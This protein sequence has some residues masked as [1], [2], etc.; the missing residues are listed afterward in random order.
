MDPIVSI[1]TFLQVMEHGSFSAAARA[2][3]V[4]VSSI[5]RQI[6]A[7]EKHL[8]TA[9]LTRTTHRL[10]PTEAGLNL[11]QHARSALGEIDD[12]I[13]HIQGIDHQLSGKIVLT[14]PLTFGQ[15][16]LTPLLPAFLNQYPALEIDI[17]LT[18]NYLNLIQEGID[19][20]IRVGE[21][22]VPDL[23]LHPLMPNHHVVCASPAYLAR[24]GTPN[25]PDELK[26]H[27]SLAHHHEH[28]ELGWSFFQ[29]NEQRLIQPHGALSTDNSGL[30]INAAINDV[31]VVLM[32]LWAV[33]KE[34]DEGLLIPILTDWKVLSPFGKGLYLATPPHRRQ[35]EKVRTLRQYLLQSLK[36]L[37]ARC[38]HV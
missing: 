6:D 30:L 17:R 36:P 26:Q 16:Y 34:I 29:G 37:S 27:T 25:T 15:K 4:A 5:T 21:H 9:V 11:M 12:A 18:D 31:G 22:E 19:L 2:A 33:W 23:I 35:S 28:S 10:T 1:R 13:R 14:A 24:H 20:A 8:G 7:L 38:G 3:D 32:P